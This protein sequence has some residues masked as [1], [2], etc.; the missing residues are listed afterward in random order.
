M[1]YYHPHSVIID[2]ELIKNTIGNEKN[3][4]DFIDREFD[5]LIGIYSTSDWT[6]GYEYVYEVKTVAFQLYDMV[7]LFNFPCMFASRGS[8]YIIIEVYIIEDGWVED[9]RNRKFSA[10]HRMQFPDIMDTFMLNITAEIV[11]NNKF[12]I[13]KMFKVL[14]SCYQNYINFANDFAVINRI[15]IK[16]SDQSC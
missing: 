3:L 16:R 8:V 11:N 1:S 15:N 7:L 2:G 13:D 9:F 10:L 14:E 12:A 4:N 5:S 6:T